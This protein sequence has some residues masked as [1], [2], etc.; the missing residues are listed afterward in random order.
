MNIYPV[1]YICTR[2]IEI[3]HAYTVKGLLRAT[4]GHASSVDSEI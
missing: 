3:D 1:C 2:F 4:R